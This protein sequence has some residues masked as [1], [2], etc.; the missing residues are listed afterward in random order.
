MQTAAKAER[1]DLE[2]SVALLP[3]RHIRPSAHNVVPR[4]P[5]QDERS[6]EA[7]SVP[8]TQCKVT[9]NLRR[10]PT[11][12]KRAAYVAVAAAISATSATPL[13]LHCVK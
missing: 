5:E 11:S 1:P 10:P 6:T 3:S 8:F 13:L 2:C 9:A 7:T 4:L 12:V